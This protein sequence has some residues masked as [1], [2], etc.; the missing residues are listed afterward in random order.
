MLGNL[1]KRSF[2]RAV[3]SLRSLTVAVASAGL[4]WLHVASAGP[5]EGPVSD[6]TAATPDPQ[7]GMVL[8]LK[9]CARCHGRHAWG[10]GPLG[11]PVLA[12]QRERYLIGE[13]ESFVRGV[14]SG[15]EMH[16]PVM[17]ERLQAPDVNRAQAFRDLAAYLSA[18]PRNPRP[19]TGPGNRLTTAERNYRKGCLSCHN[20]DGA[21]GDEHR[22]RQ[23]ISVATGLCGFHVGI[24]C[25]Y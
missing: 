3:R 15:S 12:G 21:G 19:D 20:V 25:N 7:H 5:G 10:D 1:N 6:A 23:S 9:H 13:L 18:A 11:I 4:A 8:Y 2:R 14:R 24:G 16:D 22:L 17:R